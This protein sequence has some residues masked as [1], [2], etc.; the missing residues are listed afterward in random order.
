M[1]TQLRT[2]GFVLAVASMVLVA[3]GQSAVGQQ[4]TA[5]VDHAAVLAPFLSDDTFAVAYVDLAAIDPP[6][7]VAAIAPLLDLPAPMQPQLEQMAAAAQE[8]LAKLQAAGVRRIYAVVGLGDL[9]TRGGPV[10]VIPT[11]NPRGADAIKEFLAAFGLPLGAGLPGVAPPRALN[12]LRFERHASGP[13]LLCTAASLDRYAIM[14]STPRTDLTDPLARLAGDGPAVAAVFAPGGD[15]R[16]V[17]RELWPELPPPFAPLTGELL[18]DKLRHVEFALKLPPDG[19]S[20]VAIEASDAAATDAF[21]QLIA[22]AFAAAKKIDDENVADLLRTVI[23]ALTVR[24]AGP[25][26]FVGLP[27]DDARLARLRDA[28]RQPLNAAHEAVRR[29]QRAFKL[30][31]LMKG[32]LNHESDRKHLPPAAIRDAQGR[33]LLSWRVAILPYIGQDALFRQFHLDE[34]WD[35]P[36]NRMLIAMMPDVFADPDPQF[37]ALAGDGKTTFQLPVGPDTIFFNNQGTKVSEIKDGTSG[38]IAIVEVVPERAVEWTRPADW[39]VDLNNPLD[40]VRRADRDSFAAAFCDG[41]VHIY[42]NDIPAEELRKRLTRAGGELND[43]R[44]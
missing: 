20:H 37:I 25:R 33:P 14:L 16:R 4:N 27:M 1:E 12:D 40:G 2:V 26:V 15:F 41:S 6:G 44:W 22:D 21:R 39:G 34:P 28:I 5:A 17:V 31:Q 18:G 8:S 30:Q 29:S 24:V 3:G 7:L 23:D 43:R 32:L 11:T 35:S 10:L 13:I 36:H 42:P 9:H 38:T 19:A